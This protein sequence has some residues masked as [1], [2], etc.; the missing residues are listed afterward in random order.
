[1]YLQFL[2]VLLYL[3]SD[4]IAN[5]QG[6]HFK[7]NVRVLER[8]NNWQCTSEEERERARHEIC[9]ITISVIAAI[10]AST[11]MPTETTTVFLLK[12]RPF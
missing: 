10:I 11:T 8:G 4:I 2:V 6:Q 1:M 12:I 9:Q 7:T 5:G 3:G